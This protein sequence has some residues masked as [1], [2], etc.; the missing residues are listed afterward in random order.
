MIIG[1]ALGA[2][3]LAI[4]AFKVMRL[5][6]SGCMKLVV[7]AVLVGIGAVAWYYL[8]YHMAP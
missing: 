6:M 3:V 5:V 1:I 8:R 7:L 2:I 4:V